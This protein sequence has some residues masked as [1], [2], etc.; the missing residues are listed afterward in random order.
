MKA[1]LTFILLF[2]SIF[3]YGQFE[4][5]LDTLIY[6]YTIDDD[7]VQGN[8]SDNDTATGYIEQ[9]RKILYKRRTIRPFIPFDSI[10]YEYDIQIDP[11]YSGNIQNGIE[12]GEWI[13]W[14]GHSTLYSQNSA[15]WPNCTITYK[16]D[17]IIFENG[18]WPFNKKITYVNDSS[19]VFGET[20]SPNYVIEFKCI[21]K[22]KCKYWLKDSKQ[23]ID[24]SE[25]TELEFK[26]IKV[27]IGEYDRKVQ[28][29]LNE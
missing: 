13:Y 4:F 15:I 2:L 10:Q 23:I 22:D 5:E 6:F 12:T 18:V 3:S 7:T 9:F 26:L 1:H 19:E 27:Q 14:W 11:M 8:Y 25:Y 29:I 21:N 20:S 28:Q 17:T 16:T 24:S